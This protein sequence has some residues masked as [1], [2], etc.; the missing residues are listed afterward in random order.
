MNKIISYNLFL[1]LLLFSTHVYSE[2]SLTINTAFWEPISTENNDGYFDQIMHE[3]FHR[4]DKTVQIKR[5]PAERGL[6]NANLGIDDGD[7]P[8]IE[9]LQNMNLYPNLVMVQEKLLDVEFVAFSKG[10]D[11][12]ID[13]WSD[14]SAY[15]IGIVT[16]WKILEWNISNY[17][18]LIKVKNPY[19]LFNLLKTNRVDVVII[20][21]WTGK[22]MVENFH[23]SNVTMHDDPPLAT[24]EMFLFLNK[25]HEG[26]AQEL[27]KVFY[28]M[29]ID[30]TFQGI[31]S[32][33]LKNIEL[34]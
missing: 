23:L 10:G 15:N 21:K 22:K 4:L 20:D 3:A 24:R 17:K 34:Y 11:I 27:R 28:G 8:R 19:L 30:G 32:S 1:L 9:N 12:Q 33:T 18:S 29:K 5:P 31:A 7:G 25:K 16:G 13:N 14:L 6:I 2:D 26:L